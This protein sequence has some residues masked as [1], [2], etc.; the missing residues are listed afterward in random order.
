[1]SEPIATR[2]VAP[3][4]DVRIRM[5]EGAR[6]L[7][8]G[9][10]AAAAELFEQAALLQPDYPDAPAMRGVAAFLTGDHP[11]AEA[12]LRE[13][14]V[15][16]PT[17]PDLL[18]NLGLVLGAQGRSEDEFKAYTDALRLEPRNAMLFELLGQ[19]ELRAGRAALAVATYSDLL[20]LDPGHRVARHNLAIALQE[21]PFTEWSAPRASMLVHLLTFQDI[22]LL[23][24]APAIGNL[25]R[26]RHGI[27]T[28]SED[29]PLAELANDL[30]LIAALATLYLADA[31]S[32]RFLTR[33]RTR[34]LEALE[35]EEPL[36]EPD[37][38]L[39]RLAV[40]LGLHSFA[41]DYSFMVEAK[42]GDRAAGC[43]E[44]CDATVVA[45]ADATAIRALVI[46]SMYQPIERLPG[47]DALAAQAPER[48]PRELRPLLQRTLLDV[49]DE[50]ARGASITSF[51]SSG[52]NSDADTT[53]VQVRAMYEEH[54]YPRWN[55]LGHVAAQPL[56]VLLAPAFEG[57]TPPAWT[58]GRP[59]DVLI[60]GCGTGRH[61]LR[62]ALHY[63]GARVLAI[64]LSRRALGYAQRMAERFGATNLEFLQGDLHDLPSLERRFQLIETIGSFETLHDP[65]RGWAA[66]R[67]CL[68]DDGLLHVGS[69]SE[70]ARLP[71]VRARARIAE[72]GIAATDEGMRRFRGMV[73]DGALGAE[74]LKLAAV[75]DFYSL[76]GVRDFLFHVQEHRFWLRDLRTQAQTHGLR[77]VG[78]QPLRREMRERF[79]AAH[80]DRTALRD[81]DAWV[82]F[83][84]AEPAQVAE[85]MCLAMWFGWYEPEPRVES[86]RE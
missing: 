75:G 51:G 64:D 54:P 25:V 46:A 13:A 76:S 16:A 48:W 65:A 12:K 3:L 4:P 11:L 38:D 55:S 1:M 2:A 68:A 50:L 34:V 6:L 20:A 27:V 26:H 57:W 70:P 47:A 5:N 58:D 40:A 67:A 36:A 14:L 49:R 22:E 69:Y 79:L 37:P 60:A 73:L 66:L 82:R 83:E 77:F 10:A 39:L 59:F 8:R 32:E 43:A 62:A 81:L 35:R 24:L 78:F 17:R 86:V 28:G 45:A 52:S 53:T 44:R 74:G 72:L 15:L 7:E 31:A 33:T 71:V 61:A 21:C 30:L 9:Q 56:A 41:N 19:A 84:D 80:S 85:A 42:E 29:P 23:H 63:R 18:Q